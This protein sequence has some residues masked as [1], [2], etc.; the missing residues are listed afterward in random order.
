ML[1]GSIF[2]VNFNEQ[3]CA[4]L[5]TIKQ[6]AVNI[7]SQ[8]HIYSVSNCKSYIHNILENVPKRKTLTAVTD[9][10]NQLSYWHLSIKRWR[11]YIYRTS[12]INLNFIRT[13]LYYFFYNRNTL[14]N[15]SLK[16]WQPTR[17]CNL[18]I[19]PRTIFKWHML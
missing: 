19:I 12:G 14:M 2:L 1:F 9:I 18:Y 3:K 11:C 10:K 8:K 15:D 5:V 4:T 6:I 17:Q 16:V 7:T 13:E